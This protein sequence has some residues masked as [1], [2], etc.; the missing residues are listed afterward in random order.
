MSDSKSSW[1]PSSATM[2]SPRA[3]AGSAAGARSAPWPIGQRP[4]VSL[5]WLMVRFSVREVCTDL[6]DRGALVEAR[7][8]VFACL[9][10]LHQV[11]DGVVHVDEAQVQRREAETQDVGQRRAVGVGGG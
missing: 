1:A 11:L 2:R 8:A 7:L 4:A 5:V 9:H 6:G 10:H 3:S